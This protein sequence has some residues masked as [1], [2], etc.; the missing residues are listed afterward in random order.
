M[1]TGEFAVC[2]FIGIFL[3]DYDLAEIYGWKL[4][5]LLKMGMGEK[6]F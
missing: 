3:F 1:C 6:V 5:Y 2:K 4:F